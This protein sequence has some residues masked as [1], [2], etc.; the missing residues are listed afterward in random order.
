MQRQ[1]ILS[2]NFE[3]NESRYPLMIADLAL[4]ST[5]IEYLHQGLYREATQ[6]YE[7][8]IEADPTCRSNYWHL[9]LVLLIEGD[10]LMADSIWCSILF[11]SEG[12]VTEIWTTELI[13]VLDNSIAYYFQTNNLDI[14]KLL[15]SKIIELN[16]S[17]FKPYFILGTVAFQQGQ[18]KE[19]ISYLK[20]ALIFNPNQVEI[21]ST[22][23]G[24]LVAESALDEASYYLNKAISI[25]PDNADAY[26]QLS[27]CYVY[28]K[29]TE[30]AIQN[31]KQFL[32]RNPSCGEIYVRLGGYLLI[33]KNYIEALR[34]LNQAAQLNI[35]SKEI[36]L[37]FCNS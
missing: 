23:G 15:C 31:L 33:E 13:Q 34:Y 27:L 17:Y 1:G 25:N 19:A 3:L 4:Q 9:G 2:E 35:K 32:E 11:Q 29:K 21:Y 5:G 10:Q 6:F 7:H 24:I 26:T 37:F 28:Q 18:N 14:V 30:L 22:L 16:P 12:E 20:Q 36:Y 8:C